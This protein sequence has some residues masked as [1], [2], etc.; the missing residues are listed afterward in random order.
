MSNKWIVVIF[1]LFLVIM[2]ALIM[3]SQSYNSFAFAKSTLSEYPYEGFATYQE[4]FEMREGLDPSGNVVIDKDLA[5]S[6]GSPFLGTESPFPDTK[7]PVTDTTPKALAQPAFSW[8]FFG[9]PKTS[10]SALSPKPK[11]LNPTITA[12][13]SSY[14]WRGP[15]KTFSSA[16]SPKP[17]DPNPPTQNVN[18]KPKEGFE[19][20]PEQQV[21]T[22]AG[23]TYGD[24]KPVAFLYNND[25]NITC[26]NYGYTNS[27]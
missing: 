15:P 6:T 25:A 21:S 4:A 3:G 20:M 17:K 8:S 9:E 11:D 16:L 1:I 23:S 27:K 13:L 14:D 7:P 12:W 24:E 5:P 2:L 19:T 22:L 18:P 26:K 10:S